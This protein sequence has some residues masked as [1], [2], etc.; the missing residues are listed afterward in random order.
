MYKKILILHLLGIVVTMGLSQP[1]FPQTKKGVTLL[2]PIENSCG[3]WITAR[4]RNNAEAYEFWLMGVL[5]GLNLSDDFSADFLRE[6]KVNLP[7]FWL[8]KY[9][10]ENPFKTVPEGAVQFVQD[11]AGEKTVTKPLGKE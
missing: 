6:V 8:D 5:S 4:G 1:A 2:G 10:R 9:C 3:D 7:A 11:L